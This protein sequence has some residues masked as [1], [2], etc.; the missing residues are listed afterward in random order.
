MVHAS[1]FEEITTEMVWAA[2]TGG[3]GN[4]IPVK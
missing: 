2:I 1:G 4:G 3:Q